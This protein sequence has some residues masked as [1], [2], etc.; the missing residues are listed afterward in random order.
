MIFSPLGFS[1]AGLADA[2]RIELERLEDD[3]GFFAR[4]FC[5][6][7]FAAQGLPTHWVQANI[8]YNRQAGTL[9]GLHYQ[10][11]PSIEAKIVRCIRGAIF[12]VIVDIR[13][14]SPHFGRWIGLELTAANR[15]MVYV[16]A[17]FAHGFQA[18]EPDTE[19]LY[20]HDT[21]FD[22]LRQAGL[23]ALDPAL[24]ISWPLGVTGLSARDASLPNLSDLKPLRP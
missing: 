10:S 13:A 9:R 5:M 2:C 21:M 17:G 6:E 4:A 23:N 1:A 22:P 20:L 18:L 3:R 24:G 14:D 11:A 16:P 19:L 12:D 15:S 8:S 7:E